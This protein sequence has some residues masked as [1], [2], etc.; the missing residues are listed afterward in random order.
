[1]KY[2]VNTIFQLIVLGEHYII[3][4]IINTNRKKK[5]PFQSVSYINNLDQWNSNNITT[6]QPENKMSEGNILHQTT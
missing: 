3:Y 5:Q 4:R 1:M 6:K 2:L